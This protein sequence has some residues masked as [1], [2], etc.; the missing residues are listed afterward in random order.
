[1]VS[2]VIGLSLYKKLGGGFSSELDQDT[3]HDRDP[4]DTSG[5]DGNLH[6]EVFFD[7]RMPGSRR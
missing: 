1:M 6:D 7:T 5:S 3:T 4:N 2:T